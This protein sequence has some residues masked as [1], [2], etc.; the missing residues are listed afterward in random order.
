MI[1][2]TLD[3]II[4]LAYFGAFKKGGNKS[5]FGD[6]IFSAKFEIFAFKKIRNQWNSDYYTVRKLQIPH[7][8]PMQDP[9]ICAD[10]ILRC[11]PGST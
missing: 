1:Y 3:E 10:M 4:Q 11:T 7:F 6:T 9:P 5:S 2:F 8:E